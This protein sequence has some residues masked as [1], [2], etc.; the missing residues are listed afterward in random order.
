MDAIIN[1]IS[2]LE[3]PGLVLAGIVIW[4][5]FRQVRFLVELMR[6]DLENSAKVAHILERL[7]NGRKDS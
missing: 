6:K 2:K 3:G 7:I 5:Q 4:L 1:I